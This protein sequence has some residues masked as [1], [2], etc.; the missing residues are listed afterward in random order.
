MTGSHPFTQCLSRVRS[1]QSLSLLAS[2]SFSLP[3]LLLASLSLHIHALNKAGRLRQAITTPRWHWCASSLCNATGAHPPSATPLLLIQQTGRR[4]HGS[5]GRAWGQDLFNHLVLVEASHLRDRGGLHRT[6]IML[7][8][9][10]CWAGPP[11]SA[12][13]V[14]PR[15]CVSFTQHQPHR[16]SGGSRR[17]RAGRWRRPTRTM[18]ATRR[19]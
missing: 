11:D 13:F 14:P 18:M 19:W 2:S 6:G 4:A 5:F 15:Q 1:T 10:C 7:H 8:R 12:P 16:G 17:R 9:G 3:W